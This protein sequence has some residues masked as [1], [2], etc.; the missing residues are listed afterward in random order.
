MIAALGSP[1][2]SDLRTTHSAPRQ[3]TPRLQSLPCDVLLKRFYG[4]VK[5]VPGAMY[6]HVFSPTPVSSLQVREGASLMVSG[7]VRSS[8]SC[9]CRAI[10][11]GGGAHSG[12]GISGK[13]VPHY[14]GN[15][16]RLS[17]SPYSFPQRALGTLTPKIFHPEQVSDIR[18]VLRHPVVPK[19]PLTSMSSDSTLP[20][21]TT[22]HRD[23]AG[24]TPCSIP[25]IF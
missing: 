25:F 9:T 2:T 16:A 15:S 23:I 8:L 22:T 12:A 18:M 19:Q 24:P 13:P 4:R 6:T 17:N 21:C 5:L 1:L 7:E 14:N 11:R 20:R 3:A 10:L